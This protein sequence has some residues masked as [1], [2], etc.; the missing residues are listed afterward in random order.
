[1]QQ[2]ARVGTNPNTVGS[3]LINIIWVI[4]WVFVSFATLDVFG[5]TLT[6]ILLPI[7]FIGTLLIWIFTSRRDRQNAPEEEQLS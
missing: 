5:I 4:F 2:P 3:W 1:M 7:L 6:Y